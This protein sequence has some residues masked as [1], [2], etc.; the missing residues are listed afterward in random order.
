LFR[1]I[2]SSIKGGPTREQIPHGP[3]KTRQTGVEKS[4]VMVSIDNLLEFIIS[5]PPEEG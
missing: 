2:F 1:I 3:K 4:S 5:K